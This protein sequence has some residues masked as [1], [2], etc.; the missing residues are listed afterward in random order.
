MKMPFG[1][2]SVTWELK[3]L[4]QVLSFI[5]R[6]THDINLARQLCPNLKICKRLFSSFFNAHITF[7]VTIQCYFA[8]CVCA[9]SL[10]CVQLFGTPW[11]AGHQAPLPMEFSRQEYWS[12]LP[13]VPPGNVPDPGIEPVSPALT[14]RFF[15]TEPPGKP[16][17]CYWVLN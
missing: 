17:L 10:S 15:T 13:F 12:G 5:I 1:S 16:S 9:Q 4:I 11:T 14:G 6:G 7:K 8:C 2:T 3:F